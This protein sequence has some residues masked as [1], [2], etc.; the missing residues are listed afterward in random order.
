MA[1]RRAA[2]KLAATAPAASSG[3]RRGAGRALQ[4]R[5]RACTMHGR[6][7]ERRMLHASPCPRMQPMERPEHAK[8]CARRMAPR[9][10]AGRRRQRPRRRSCCCMAASRAAVAM[11]IRRRQLYA[12][13]A[14]RGHSHKPVARGAGLSH[15]KHPPRQ[16]AHAQIPHAARAR[17]GQDEGATAAAEALLSCVA[18]IDAAQHGAPLVYAAPGFECL[19]GYTA[20]Q[21]V[22]RQCVQV[23]MRRRPALIPDCQTESAGLNQQHCTSVC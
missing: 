5:V 17:C 23:Q 8:T 14:D 1:G 15:Q 4:V 9:M 6:A 21:L 10:R 12:R 22:G 20:A 18:I 2:T 16:C 19:T 13:G 11:Q 7:P 3:R